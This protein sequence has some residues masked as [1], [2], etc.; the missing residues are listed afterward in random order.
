MPLSLTNTIYT[1]K[2]NARLAAQR[3]IVSSTSTWL[4][5]PLSGLWRPLFIQVSRIIQKAV[6]YQLWSSALVLL[7]DL[8]S[9]CRGTEGPA[10]SMR[11]KPLCQPFQTLCY[12]TGDFCRGLSI[13]KP[14]ACQSKTL[15]CHPALMMCW[16]SETIHVN[17]LLHACFPS[18]KV[19]NVI[20]CGVG[21]MSK[22]FTMKNR[23][24]KSVDLTF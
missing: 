2:I 15:G 18:L 24:M 4:S 7:A 17:S 3:S 22:I 13:S 10:F 8:C 5:F 23:A 11:G 21:G 1:A 20:M 12:P 14:E 9:G 16:L 6:P 19:N